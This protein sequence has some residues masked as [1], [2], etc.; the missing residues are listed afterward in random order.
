MKLIFYGDRALQ[1]LG[2]VASCSLMKNKGKEHYDI[3][4]EFLEMSDHGMRILHEFIRSL[5]DKGA[6]LS[7]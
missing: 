6:G 2:R 4:I 1:F 3:G 5:E 7:T